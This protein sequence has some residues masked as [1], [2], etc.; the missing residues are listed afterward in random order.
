MSW[1]SLF[2]EKQ[3]LKHKN[4]MLEETVKNNLIADMDYRLKKHAYDWEVFKKNF[5]PLILGGILFVI[6]YLCL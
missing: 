2:T 1:F 5:L 4:A 6:I 3:R